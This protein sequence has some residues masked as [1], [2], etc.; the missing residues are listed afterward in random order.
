MIAIYINMDESQ[1]N[2]VTNKKQVTEKKTY[3]VFLII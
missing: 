1:E 2:N 3:T